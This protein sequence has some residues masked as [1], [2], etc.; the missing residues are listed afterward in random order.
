MKLRHRQLQ[1]SPGN[2]KKVGRA[3]F[4]I[5]AVFLFHYLFQQGLVTIHHIINHIS[6][7]DRLEML[8]CAVN[9][10]FLNEPELHGGH[11]AFR[12]SNKVDMLHATF[13]ES[14]RSVRIIMS[15]RCCDI[16]AIRQLHINRNICVGVQIGCKIALV[17][18]II[19]DMI[20]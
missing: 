3:V 18:G 10:R 8:S 16:E 15:D 11:R 4:E 13:I 19:H 2:S 6:V 17:C 14:N 7:A 20:V 1:K 12:L 9:F 5:N